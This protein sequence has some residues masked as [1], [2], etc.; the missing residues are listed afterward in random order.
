MNIPR[1][2]AITSFNDINNNLHQTY[3]DTA[4]QSMKSA[5]NE[6]RMSIEPG[7]SESDIV[8]CQVSID[9]SWYKQGHSSMNAFVS[10][11]STENK[12]VIDYQVFS[13]FCKECLI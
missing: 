1:P 3:I 9:G 6:V 5:A 4:L 8:D 10:A 11:I 12:K 13:K 7:S 2:L